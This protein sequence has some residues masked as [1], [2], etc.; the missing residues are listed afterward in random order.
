MMEDKK[1]ILVLVD[2][3]AP[4][5]KAGGPI[6]SCVNFAF[7]LKEAFDVFVLTT[8][9]DHGDTAPYQGI[10]TGKWV[11]NLDAGFKVHYMKKASL[12]AGHLKHE[13]KA[14]DADYVYLNHLFS[15]LF[16]VFPLWLKFTGRLKSKIVLCPRGALYDSA[17]SVKKWKKTPFLKLFKWMGIHKKILFH[18]TNQ[19]E[20]EAIESFFPGSTVLI[21]DNLPKSNQP[22]FRSLLK[23]S[24]HIKCVFIARIF[25]IKNLLFFL[26]AL[27]GVGAQ[28]EFT[29]V[30]PVEHREYWDECCEKI[31]GLGSNIKVD[32]LGPRRNDEL[33][34]ILA[35]HHL[36]VLPTTGENFGHSIFEAFLA[37]RPVLISDQTPWLG[38]PARRIGWDLSLGDPGAFARVVEEAATWDQQQFDDWAQAAWEYA[39]QFIKN[40]ELQNQY[41]KLFP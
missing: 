12:T 11:S 6:Q 16:V 34:G 18:A 41:L 15:P 14:L 29:I 8:D 5:Y 1:K 17:L 7:S 39:R 40:P 27:Q 36:Y 20:K 23:V 33:P 22:A 4:G 19:R 3:F 26:K 28:V 35:Q 24:G 30:G 2:W 38:L 31:S 25:P 9:T 10:P 32:Y 13:I 21:A 37:G